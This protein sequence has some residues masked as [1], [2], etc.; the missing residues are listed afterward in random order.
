MIRS[1]WFRARRYCRCAIPALLSAVVHQLRFMGRILLPIIIVSVALPM[2]WF[3]ISYYG[4]DMFWGIIG[5]G[6]AGFFGLVGLHHTARVQLA[7]RRSPL[8]RARIL[9]R[10]RLA[11]LRKDPL[12]SIFPAIIPNPM[13][14]I[15]S[16]LLDAQVSWEDTIG[17]PASA[18]DEPFTDEDFGLKWIDGRLVDTATGEIVS[19]PADENV[20]TPRIDHEPFES[21]NRNHDQELQEY[22]HPEDHALEHD[23]FFFFQTDCE[24]QLDLHF[25]D[26]KP[27]KPIAVV[28]IP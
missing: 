14:D 25:P 4:P 17:D 21:T 19:F 5:G 6:S 23:P 1:L 2:F 16:D 20:E 28:L 24:D 13:S 18:P 15:D 11:R 3:L 9:I 7:D 8:F 26:L 12:D 10:S 22:L 27:V